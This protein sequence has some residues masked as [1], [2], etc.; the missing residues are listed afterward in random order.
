MTVTNIMYLPLSYS[1]DISKCCWEVIAGHLIEAEVPEI[2][3]N[4]THLFSAVTITS[5]VA[6]PHVK[7]LVRKVKGRGELLVIDDPSITRVN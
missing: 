1:S 3:H 7:A 2:Q 5:T 4:R 6:K